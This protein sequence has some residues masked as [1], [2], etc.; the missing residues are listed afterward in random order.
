MPP[1]HEP[2]SETQRDSLRLLAFRLHDEVEKMIEGR[3][4]VEDGYLANLHLRAEE[5]G[6]ALGSEYAEMILGSARW[7]ARRF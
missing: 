2:A 3:E 6:N 4:A 1:L 7:L 5:I